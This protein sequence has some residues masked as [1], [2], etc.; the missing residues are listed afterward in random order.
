MLKDK[1]SLM[2]VRTDGQRRSR[3]LAT[4]DEGTQLQC[5]VLEIE[6]TDGDISYFLQVKF[7]TYQHG[8]S[9]SLFDGDHNLVALA[10]P[11][12]REESCW[13]DVVRI[14]EAKGY[15]RGE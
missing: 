11:H 1:H 15:W 12:S 14:L 8:W 10:G 9:M 7:W 2:P 5:A 4:E 3:R 6:D 13:K